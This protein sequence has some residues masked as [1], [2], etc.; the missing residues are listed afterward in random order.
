MVIY[1]FNGDNALEIHKI[2]PIEVEGCWSRYRAYIDAKDD[3]RKYNNGYKG[4]NWINL[5]YAEGEI[6]Y[7]AFWLEEE[8]DDRA[9]EIVENYSN[10]LLEKKRKELE[11]IE[12]KMGVV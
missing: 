7:K 2:Y 9:I 3:P 6:L 12:K 4:K 5:S 10:E 11:K 8:D 1:W